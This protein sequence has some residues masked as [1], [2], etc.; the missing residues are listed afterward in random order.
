V[1]IGL[2]K[3][4]DVGLTETVGESGD[5]FELWYRK[6]TP[7][8]TFVLQASSAQVCADWVRDVSSLLWKQTLCNRRRQQAE[9][10]CLGVNDRSSFDLTPSKHN[11]YDRFVD[12][13]LSNNRT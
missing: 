12:V 11:I 3:M 7:S 4:T 5:T 10:A 6:R 8:T 2:C 9:L 13:S 1:T